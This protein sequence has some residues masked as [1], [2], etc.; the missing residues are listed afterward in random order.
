MFKHIHAVHQANYCVE[1]NLPLSSL[2]KL[3]SPDRISA[4]ELNAH[5]TVAEKSAKQKDVQ[6]G[7]IQ[8]CTITDTHGVLMT[9]AVKGIKNTPRKSVIEFG[10]TVGIPQKSNS[11]TYFHMRGATESSPNPTPFNRPANYGVYAFVCSVEV[12]RI[13]FND[14]KRGYSID[15]PAR[16]SRYK[17]VVVSLLNSFINPQG[18]MTSTQKPHI[19]DLKGVVS[20]SSK[21]IP[22]P[23]ISAINEEYQTQI[24]KIVTNLNKIEP[25]A[26]ELK[27]FDG[28]GKLSEILAELINYEPYKIA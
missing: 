4:D 23:T 6:D 5:I 25:D 7:F 8:L 14:I 22:A 15:D 27:E 2:A 3:L 26:I 13:G 20:I 16:E 1:H 17:S 24:E 12:Y 10:W 9:D 19:T 11:D 28:L 21:L 18:A